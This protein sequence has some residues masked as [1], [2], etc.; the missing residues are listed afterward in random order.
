[1]RLRSSSW[2]LTC[3]S[4]V[5]HVLESAVGKPLSGGS[6]KVLGWCPIL[7]QDL[8]AGNMLV[9]LIPSGLA[10]PLGERHTSPMEFIAALNPA[11]DSPTSCGHRFPTQVNSALRN[12]KH[13]GGRW[14]G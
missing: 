2:D 4:R 9:E 11:L 1:M 5:G 7:C 6:A 13:E 12:G 3:G 10:A 14:A 8:G